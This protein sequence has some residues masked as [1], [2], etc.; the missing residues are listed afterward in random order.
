MTARDTWGG[1]CRIVEWSTH[2][3]FPWRGGPESRFGPRADSCR[4]ESRF[5]PRA[6]SRRQSHGRVTAL[7]K[8]HDFDG[9]GCPPSQRNMTALFFAIAF[10]DVEVAKALMFAGA[11]KDTK[12]DVSRL[13]VG[14]N[15]NQRDPSE[16]E[17]GGT[18]ARGNIKQGSR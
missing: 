15:Y 14:H 3:L 8:A 7:P 9:C 17:G 1:E 13:V 18:Q 6:D 16:R 11:N 4:P 10:G 2:I 12:N 5:G